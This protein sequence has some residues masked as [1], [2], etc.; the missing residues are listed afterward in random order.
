MQRL[1]KKW[2]KNLI[3]ETW[4]IIQSVRNFKETL[5]KKAIQNAFCKVVGEAYINEKAI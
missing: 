4:K 2:K 3:L 5:I 1:K